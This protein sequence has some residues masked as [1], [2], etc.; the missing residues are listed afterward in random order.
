[1]VLRDAAGLVVDSLNYGLLVDPWAAE[2][3]QATSGAGESGCRAPVAGPGRGGGA[4]NGPGAPAVSS[5]N[6]SAGRFP[7]GLDTDSNCTDFLLQPAAT[8]SAASAAGATNIKVASVADFAAGQTIMIDAGAS[9]ET[10]VIAKVGTAGRVRLTPPRIWARP[11]SLSPM[12]RASVS[13][14]R[15][16][17]TV[18]ERLRRRLSP[19]RVGA[20]EARRHN[21]GHS[22]LK[23]AHAASAQVSGSGITITGALTRAHSSGSQVVGGVPTPGA[24][25]KYSRSRL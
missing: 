4:F 21:Y 15:S 9:L 16:P 18:A 14:R 17:L 22:P 25:N 13:A 12:R 3:Y 19:P 7:D 1:M 5:P 20:A 24:T 2:G 11:F 6:R 10:A 8:L 23:L